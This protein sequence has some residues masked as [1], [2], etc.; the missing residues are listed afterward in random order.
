MEKKPMIEMDYIDNIKEAEAKYYAL[1][2]LEAEIL[3][4]PE[5]KLLYG[6]TQMF[7]DGSGR[8]RGGHSANIG[9]TSGAMAGKAFEKVYGAK[10]TENTELYGINKAINETIGRIM[11]YSHDL[12]HTPLGHD[13]ESVLE[14][15]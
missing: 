9:Q 10:E 15:N 11:G 4:S 3:D 6:K 5:Y 8:S 14:K 7:Y 13:G 12:G 1:L 2:A